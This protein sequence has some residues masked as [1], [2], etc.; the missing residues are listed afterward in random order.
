VTQSDCA[1]FG[2]TWAGPNTTCGL[3]TCPPCF[4]DIN[5]NGSVDVDDLIAVILAWGPCNNCPPD[6]DPPPFGNNQVNTDDLIM[7]IVSWGACP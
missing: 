3:N 2:G 7:V 4:A 5:D 1:L 6:I